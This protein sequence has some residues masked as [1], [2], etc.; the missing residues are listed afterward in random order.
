MTTQS[1]NPAR[2]FTLNLLG[3]LHMLLLGS[4]LFGIVKAAVTKKPKPKSAA[5]LPSNATVGHGI[6][7]RQTH[8]EFNCCAVLNNSNCTDPT[9]CLYADPDG[10]SLFIHCDQNAVAWA[11]YCPMESMVRILNRGRFLSD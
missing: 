7:T 4:V 1:L 2:T 3:M 6:L 10:C 8:P 5:L 11:G 9:E